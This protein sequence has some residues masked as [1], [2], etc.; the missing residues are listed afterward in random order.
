[1]ADALFTSLWA[2]PL[3]VFALWLSDYEFTVIGAKLYK[4]QDKVVYQG[5]YE[6]NPLT[7]RDVD[8]S[9]RIGF[10]IIFKPLYIAIVVAVVGAF[11]RSSSGHSGPYA[12]VLGAFVLAQLAIHFRH[13]QSWYLFKRV[14]PAAKGR[15]EYP[16][17]FRSSALQLVLFAVLFFVLYVV[18]GSLFILGGAVMCCVN[19]VI[20]YRLALKHD[21]YQ[22][23]LA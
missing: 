15:I 22:S 10:R 3:L 7:Q 9:R 5:S 4:A 14:V 20:H 21:A 16:R 12:L 18:T 8:A 6:L 23:K 1:M 19:A 17:G 13:F 2:G 11:F